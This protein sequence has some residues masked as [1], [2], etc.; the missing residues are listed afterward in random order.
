M[1]PED[2]HHKAVGW[3]S[4]VSIVAVI[5]GGVFALAE[6]RAKKT[7]ERRLTTAGYI[8]TFQGTAA[9]AANDKLAE[10]WEVEGMRT[11]ERVIAAPQPDQAR[12]YSDGV[13]ALVVSHES[14]SAI[15][16]LMGFYEDV[17]FCAVWDLCDVGLTRQFFENRGRTFFRKYYP[18]I[19]RLRE[20]WNDE[21]IWREAEF[22]YNQT[23]GSAV[24]ET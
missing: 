22:Y 16:Y 18:Y 15:R 14:E 19:C 10:V 24:C 7:A 1:S 13:N 11:I 9:F 6:Y 20:K 23:R 8:R 12:I 5:F 3:F 2:F 17:A 21:T 4:I